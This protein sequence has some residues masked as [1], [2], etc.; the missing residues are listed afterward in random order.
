M[1]KEFEMTDEQLKT[2]MDACKPVPYMVF[3]GREPRSPQENA[4][5]TWRDLGRE[6]GFDHMSVRPIQGKNNKFFRAKIIEKNE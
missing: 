3:G 2:L 4:N 6:L 5:D 1:E